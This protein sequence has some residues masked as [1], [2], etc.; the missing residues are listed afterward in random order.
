MK[1]GDDGTEMTFWGHLEVFRGVLFRCL[2]VWAGC[3]VVAFCFKEQLFG[4]V[5]APSRADFVLYRGLC[6][7]GEW[8]HM[9]SLCP[10]DFEAQFINTELASQFLVHMQVAL[11]AGCVAAFP[12]LIYQLYGFIA[13]A[14]YEQEKKY[15]AS[16]IGCSVLLF[17]LGVLLNYFII[18]PFAF[19]FLS[20]YQ[21]QEAVVNQIALSS[22]VSTLLML[23][24]LMG[25]LFELPILAFFLAKMGIVDAPMLKQ[26]R[27]HAFVVILIVAAVITP[28]GDIFTLTL[29][30][31]PIYMLYEVSILIVKKSRP[32]PTTPVQRGS[33]RFRGVQ[34]G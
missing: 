1:Q 11:V 14:L 28:T 20:T 4:L 17:A 32:H 5:F 15:S 30:S 33:E 18:F 31:L 13:P 22:Y 7:L 25:I 19:R 26:Y 10:G 29:A 2:A 21:V 24:L 3:T 27:R 8:W 23:S 6:R 16:L 12:Y 34:K 9:S